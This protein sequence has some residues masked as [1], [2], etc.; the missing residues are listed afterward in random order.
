VPT[1]VADAAPDAALDLTGRE[2][3]VTKKDNDRGSAR[4]GE[5]A[6]R[7]YARSASRARQIVSFS[8]AGR[9]E[10]ERHRRPPWHPWLRIY[11]VVRVMLGVR[12]VDT[13]EE[14][15]EDLVRVVSLN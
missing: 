1:S 4:R 13:P 10:S 11:R 7:Q 5:P 14:A 12:A 9:R 2:T 15:Q 3:V 6:P 8:C